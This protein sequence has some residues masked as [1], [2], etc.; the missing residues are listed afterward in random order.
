MNLH[1]NG[2]T[3]LRIKDMY[4]RQTDSIGAGKHSLRSKEWSWQYS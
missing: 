3:P 2:D 4:Q 1:Y